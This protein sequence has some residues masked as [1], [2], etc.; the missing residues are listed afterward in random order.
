MFLS[1]QL[2]A[3]FFSSI[4]PRSVTTLVLS[5][6][7]VLLLL[8]LQDNVG[9]DYKTYYLF[10]QLDYFGPFERRYEW[11]S[12]AIFKLGKLTDIF[13]LSLSIFYTISIVGLS[14]S[15]SK[16][17]NRKNDCIVVL[18]LVVFAA[19]FLVNHLNLMRYL[20]AVSLWLALFIFISNRKRK[21]KFSDWILFLIPGLL[22]F[23][24]ML[25]T[26]LVV[27]WYR[28]DVLKR[29]KVFLALSVVFAMLP[30][31]VF[32]I[33]N[34]YEPIA[35][36]NFGSLSFIPLSKVYLL[37]IFLGNVY[38]FFFVKRFD[39]DNALVN[40]LGLSLFLTPISLLYWDQVGE[41]LSYFVILAQ[42]FCFPLSMSS[43]KLS[44]DSRFLILL[45]YFSVLLSFSFYKFLFFR[46]GEY[47]YESI[48][49]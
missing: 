43:L 6:L 34:F 41:R 46:V 27:V 7:P 1:A 5:L 26:L 47:R 36:I 2:F 10:F 3:L 17:Y 9:T 24:T 42:C 22:H 11:L 38:A 19:N 25:L 33:F 15:I 30:A 21:I 16:S 49:Y 28:F 12:V 39:Q 29:R 35:K 44:R 37:P 32:S 8:V 48:L 45:T 31:G 40:L 13:Q 23:S 14:Y 20:T 4:L 18:F